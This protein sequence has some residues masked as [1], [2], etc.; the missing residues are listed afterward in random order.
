MSN[1]EPKIVRG[2]GGG[3]LVTGPKGEKFERKFEETPSSVTTTDIPIGDSQVEKKVTTVSQGASTTTTYPK[4][5]PKIV[6]DIY[7]GVIVTQPTGEKFARDISRDAF[8]DRPIDQPQTTTTSKEMGIK[9][10]DVMITQQVPEASGQRTSTKYTA[11]E[12]IAQKERGDILFKGEPSYSDI[13][14]RAKAAGYPEGIAKVAAGIGIVAGGATKGISD[15]VQGTAETAGR[16]RRVFFA[17]VEAGEKFES[18]SELAVDVAIGVT[19]VGLIYA[20]SQAIKERGILAGLSYS[21]PGAVAVGLGA[22]S[23]IKSLGKLEGKSFM[24]EPEVLPKK[25]FAPKYLEPKLPKS[26]EI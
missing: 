7:G 17:N 20:G 21:I 6:K 9:A 24:F 25:E 19:G 10:Q 2:P 16:A 26:Y 18:P 23:G 12:H 11:E 13:E 22:R 1:G 5:E 8:R 4:G 3:I 15:L 14:A